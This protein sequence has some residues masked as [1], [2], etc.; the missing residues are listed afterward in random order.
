VP[1]KQGRQSKAKIMP[2]QWFVPFTRT[3]AINSASEN[4]AEKNRIFGTEFL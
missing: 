4:L 2:G 1:A 3:K